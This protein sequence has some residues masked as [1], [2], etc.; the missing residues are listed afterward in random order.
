TSSVRIARRGARRRRAARARAATATAQQRCPSQP[1]SDQATLGSR[2]PACASRTSAVAS[3]PV[4][5]FE[6]AASGSHTRPSSPAA[7][8]SGTRIAASGTPTMFTS[9]ERTGTA[10][11]EPATSDTL[12]S[13]AATLAAT[14]CARNAR[15]RPRGPPLPAAAGSS[16]ARGEGIALGRGRARQAGQ[17]AGEE[18][19]ADE[20]QVRELERRVEEHLRLQQQRGARGQR[21]HRPRSQPADPGAEGEQRGKRHSGGAHDA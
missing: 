3:G 5:T 8:P 1:T 14:A 18:Q 19:E 9:G 17:G 11:N 20:G 16:G 12:G 4:T 2:A 7:N 15:A 6:A 13:W 10:P 21:Q